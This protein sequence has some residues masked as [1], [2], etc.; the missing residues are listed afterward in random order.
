MIEFGQQRV[1]KALFVNVVADMAVEIAIGAFGPA[2]R[3]MD[4]KPETGP[5]RL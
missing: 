2:K 5:S 1:A 4:I 3:P